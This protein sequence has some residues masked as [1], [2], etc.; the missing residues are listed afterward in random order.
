MQKVLYLEKLVLIFLLLLSYFVCNYK[1]KILAATVKDVK[2]Y[3]K[4]YKSALSSSNNKLKAKDEN[5]QNNTSNKIKLENKFSAKIE[6]NKKAKVIESFSGKII[7]NESYTNIASNT[8]SNVVSNNLRHYTTNVLKMPYMINNNYI[9]VR[10]LLYDISNI[11][12]IS[13]MIAREVKGMLKKD[14]VRGSCVEDIL[15][16]AL[17][18]LGYSFKF[19]E[20]CLF[21]AKKINLELLLDKIYT[22][23]KSKLVPSRKLNIDFRN[24]DLGIICKILSEIAGIEIRISEQ[25]SGNMIM[26]IIDMPYE[27]VLKGI[28]YLNGY[29][30]LETDFSIII[31]P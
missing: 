29:K 21:V 10:D 4:S 26:R 5:L 31:V 22:P 14:E 25:I 11:Y 20:N 7:N 2:G 6:E 24:V 15:E 30:M 8:V 17:K 23:I 18:K 28:V 27:T 9:D 13:L 3:N 1:L 19:R 16:S 12:G